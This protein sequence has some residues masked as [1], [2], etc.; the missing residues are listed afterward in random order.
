VATD[1]RERSPVFYARVAGFIYLFAMAM[2]IF[3]Q[4]FVLGGLRGLPVLEH[5]SIPGDRR[6]R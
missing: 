3:S 5:A 2:G 4:S 6:R 1:I